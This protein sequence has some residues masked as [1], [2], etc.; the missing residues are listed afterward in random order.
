MKN[1]RFDCIHFKSRAFSLVEVVLALGICV[2]SLITMLGLLS[3]GLNLNH[4]SRQVMRAADLATLLASERRDSPTN[5]LANIVLPTL[6]QTYP[7]NPVTAFVNFA[8]QSTTQSHAAFQ[9][10]YQVGTNSIVPGIGFI[11]MRFTWPPGAN[12]NTAEGQ[13]ELTTQVLMPQ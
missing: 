13:Y 1:R 2:F 5:T 10:S 11:Y 3:M 4:D 9:L 12:P 6:A 7:A 8:G